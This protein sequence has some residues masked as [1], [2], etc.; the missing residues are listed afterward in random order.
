MARHLCSPPRQLPTSCLCPLYLP[1]SPVTAQTQSSHGPVTAHHALACL[2]C[3]A[4]KWCTLLL[5]T[6]PCHP[7]VQITML[8]SLLSQLKVQAVSTQPRHVLF[9]KPSGGSAHHHDAPSLMAPALS[10]FSP[11]FTTPEPLGTPP[12]PTAAGVPGPRGFGTDPLSMLGFVVEASGQTMDA[13]EAL[14]ALAEGQLHCVLT[15]DS[16]DHMLQHCHLSVLETVMRS[17]VVFARMKLHQKGQ[18]MGLLGRRGL[19][20]VTNGQRRHIQVSTMCH[21]KSATCVLRRGDYV[22]AYTEQ[23]C[24]YRCITV[25]LLV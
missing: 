8:L 9:S 6:A 20:Q 11:D 23:I 3:H 22:R 12:S 5:W 16:F 1:T 21:H 19:S 10:M 24:E 4:I 13:A 18:V 25:C 17:T 7:S 15:G 2:L 14:N